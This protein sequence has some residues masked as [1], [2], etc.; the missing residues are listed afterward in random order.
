MAV[1]QL[2]QQ[3]AWS[4]RDSMLDSSTIAQ[5]QWAQRRSPGWSSAWGSEPPPP[6]SIAAAQLA[7]QYVISPCTRRV[8]GSTIAT[9]QW[10][11]VSASRAITNL[12]RALAW[13]SA[14]PPS[15]VAQGSA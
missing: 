13:A 14:P 11:Q 2:R 4:P 5:P 10:A 12:L 1:A 3:Y 9:P 6:C 15:R 7:Q 8:V